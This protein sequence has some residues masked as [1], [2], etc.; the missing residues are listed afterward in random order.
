MTLRYGDYKRIFELI[1]LA[2]S[3]PDRGV[4][5]QTFCEYFKKLVPIDSAAYAP[6]E[7]KTPEFGFPGALTYQMS[8]LPLYLFVE[9]YATVHPYHLL[10]GQ[11]GV[12]KYINRG[13]NMTDFVTPSHLSNTEYGQ[14]FQPVAHVF[15]EMCTLL[16]SQGDSLGTMGFHRR[17]GERDFSDREKKIFN[18][19]LPHLARAFHLLDLTQGHIPSADF[20][21]IVLGPS[22]KPLS[23]NEEATRILNGRPPQ[24]IP[25]PGLCAGSTFFSTHTGIY[26]VRT[27]FRRPNQESRTLFLQRLPP[28]QLLQSKLSVTGLTRRQAEVAAFA[29]QGLS[30]REIAD[31]LFVTEQTVKDHLHDVFEHL[32]ITRRSEL[33]AK[34]MALCPESSDDS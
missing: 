12:S 8:M 15:Y 31:R 17:K 28:Q 24:S 3:I 2:Y 5:F 14:D 20:G 1:D 25:E 6:A 21:E 10:V 30:N 26:R 19:L 16:G 34:V 32:K 9:H 13:T 23:M 4:M 29:I 7:S 11:E 33:A 22:G 27:L 18:L